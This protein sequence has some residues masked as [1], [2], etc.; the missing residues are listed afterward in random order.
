MPALLIRISRR[1]SF[2][3]SRNSARTDTS[4][5]TSSSADFACRPASRKPSATERAASR[6]RLVIT[7]VQP[8]RA[9][10]EAIAC[11]MPRLAPVTT[12]TLP[13]KGVG[14]GWLLVAILLGS[15]E[16]QEFLASL[17]AVAK[18]AEHRRGYG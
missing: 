3:I 11:P 1:P 7:V 4:L 6:R 13:A 17:R 8:R 9:S 16:R 12:A 14:N 5:A 15:N 2:L 18:Y 10:A